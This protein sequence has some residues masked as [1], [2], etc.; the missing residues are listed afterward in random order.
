M[1]VRADAREVCACPFALHRYPREL[2]RAP[3]RLVGAV[4][5]V[6]LVSSAATLDLSGSTLTFTLGPNESGGMTGT[7]ATITFTASSAITRTGTGTGF[8]AGTSFGGNLATSGIT[9]VVVNG[10]DVFTISSIDT[11]MPA[12]LT[13]ST[14]TVNLRNTLRTDGRNVTFTG[15]NGVLWGGGITT[16]GTYT[17]DTDALGGT[18]AAGSIEIAGPET[19]PSIGGNNAT[20]V[21]DASA[22]GGGAP[23]NVR[24]MGR[25]GGNINVAGAVVSGNAVRLGAIYV[26]SGCEVRA[27]TLELTGP[28]QTVVPNG[29]GVLKL[30]PIDDGAEMQLGGTGSA[31]LHL[32]AAELTHLFGNSIRW[33]A[34]E[35]GRA[36]GGDVNVLGNLTLDS[37]LTFRGAVVRTTAGAITFTTARALVF[38]VTNHVELGPVIRASSV[39]ILA[40]GDGET[41]T[42]T[43]ALTTPTL[44]V[45]GDANLRFTHAANAIGTLSAQLQ[46][47]GALELSQ[48]GALNVASASSQ[49]GNVTLASGGGISATGVSA[50]TI[51][52]TAS[53]LTVTS[54]QAAVGLSLVV[55][56]LN[57]QQA[58][59]GSG[60]GNTAQVTLQPRTAG[61][62]IA[63][64]GTPNASQLVLSSSTLAAFFPSLAGLT[65]ET[66]G[67]LSVNGAVTLPA[68]TTLVGSSIAV[69]SDVTSTRPLTLR[70]ATTLGAVN[71]ALTTPMLTIDGQLDLGN[72][73]LNV[74]GQLAFAPSSTLTS[75]VDSASSSGRIALTGSVDLTNV[76]L[77]LTGTFN[78]PVGSRVPLI[79]NDGTDAVVGTFAGLAELADANFNHTRVTYVDDGND[80]S[81][82]KFSAPTGI[83]LTGNSVL[84]FKPV[85][86]RIGV[87]ATDGSEGEART[88]AFVSGAG[89]THNAS[90][91]ISGNELLTAVEFDFEAG[92]QK[93]LRVSSTDAL[94]RSVEQALSV[95]ILDNLAPVFT[96][97]PQI[98]ALPTAPVTGESV[99]FTAPTA[100]PEGDVVN[101]SWDYGDGTIDAT[102]VHTFTTAG[103]FTVKAS[104]SDPYDSTTTELVLVVT[105]PTPD[106]VTLEAADGEH[107]LAKLPGCGCSSADAFSVLGL[108]LLA[109]LR[110]RSRA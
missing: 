38:E 72:R 46:G 30:A 107:P 109:L 77:G 6:S 5:F 29:A 27:R 54:V 100:A 98:S 52:I 68:A 75:S 64:G 56:Q 37:A 21:L 10:G 39:D 12:S 92:A 51:S 80:V 97:S 9:S 67:P 24:V 69:S 25:I 108:G 96:A 55:D 47:A 104:A 8:N 1:R 84:E 19:N 11:P 49:S 22:D 62:A 4:F 85:G 58:G 43:V 89:D 53:A 81:L 44:T 34:V 70:G 101:V 20:V 87:L 83:S 3:Q 23:G 50:P 66:T 13:V 106:A 15:S 40:D 91:S 57:I 7:G 41:S 59:I 99:Q 26:H 32:S 110:R 105:A 90:F 94:G 63:L 71:V 18:G 35:L 17:I 16:A 31:P 76:T 88:F 73:T 78:P 2:V 14:P 86:T 33:G 93:S 42:Q 103:S 45:G 102:G 65:L 79:I 82:I 28:I 36:G 95:S 61:R 60:I 48:R 74:V